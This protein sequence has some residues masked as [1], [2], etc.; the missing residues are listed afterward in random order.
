M[1]WE[2]VDSCGSGQGPVS[3]RLLRTVL[4]NLQVN[5]LL[6]IYG[7]PKESTAQGFANQMLKPMLATLT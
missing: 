4:T 1:G 3:S 7:V 2:G 5:R 6:K